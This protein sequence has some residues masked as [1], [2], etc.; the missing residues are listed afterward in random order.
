MSGEPVEFVKEAEHVGTVRSTD[1]NLTH[2]L[3]RFSAHRKA[4]S[5]VLPA[6]MAKGHR[7][8][9]AS[10]IN[11]LKTYGTPV[12]LSGVSTLTL[13]KS[14]TKLVDQNLKFYL[15]NL[16]KLYD[17]TPHVLPIFLLVIYLERL[18]FI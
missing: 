7:A 12:L 2:I 3:S 16:Q 18:C 10:T 5:A 13:S 8:N 14:E 11:A 17:K 4:M 9:P 15:Q 6:G 1:G